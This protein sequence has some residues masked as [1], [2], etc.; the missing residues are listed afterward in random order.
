MYE[1]F[2]RLTRTY[3]YVRASSPRATSFSC[4]ITTHVPPGAAH[5]VAEKKIIDIT[6]S[7]TGFNKVK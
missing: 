6:K 2:V 4:P 1:Y 7:P 3:S 5:G